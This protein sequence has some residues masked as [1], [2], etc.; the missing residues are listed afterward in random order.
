MTTEATR[1]ETAFRVVPIGK[2]TLTPGNATLTLRGFPVSSEY[3]C[4]M[5]LRYSDRS[6]ANAGGADWL[7]IV[8]CGCL[9]LTMSSAA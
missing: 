4:F 8:R 1:H 3:N 2:L 5:N 7:A 6:R 9:T